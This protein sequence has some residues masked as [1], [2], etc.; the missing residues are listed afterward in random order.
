MSCNRASY[1]CVNIMKI[2]PYDPINPPQGKYVICNI[3]GSQYFLCADIKDDKEI[4]SEEDI[5]DS[6]EE[7]YLDIQSKDGFN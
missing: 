1:Y 7:T 6:I 2:K 3:D 5:R 4:A